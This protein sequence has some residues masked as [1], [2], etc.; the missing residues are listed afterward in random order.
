MAIGEE[1][2]IISYMMSDKSLLFE[3]DYHILIR[4]HYQKKNQK[5]ELVIL[6]K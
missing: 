2:E 6:Q 3:E 4:Q 5:P 1:M